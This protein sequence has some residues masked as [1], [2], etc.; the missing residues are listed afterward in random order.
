MIL[1]ASEIQKVRMASPLSKTF[2]AY[3]ISSVPSSDGTMR[4]APS[5]I[6]PSESAPAATTQNILQLDSE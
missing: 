3:V 1:R 6:S 4:A 5:K 2:R